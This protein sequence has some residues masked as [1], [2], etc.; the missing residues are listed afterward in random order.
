[1]NRMEEIFERFNLSQEELLLLGIGLLFLSLA[2]IFVL[3]L[4]ASRFVKSYFQRRERRLKDQYGKILNKIIIHETYSKPG[5]RVSSFDFRMA[6]LRLVMGHSNF[7]QQ[8]LIGHLLLMKKNLTGNAVGAILATYR[9][10]ELYKLSLRKLKSLQWQKK[11][12]GIR[13][14]AEMK[15]E[16]G[17]RVIMRFLNARN[18]TL[19]EEIFMALVRMEEDNPLFFLDQYNGTITH[20]MLINIHY[21]LSRLDVRKLPLFSRWFSHPDI[22]VVIFSVHMV[23]Q[24]RQSASIPGVVSLLATD[25]PRLLEIVI[26][27]L[28]EL[29]AYPYVEDVLRLTERVWSSEGLSRRLVRCVGSLG[30]PARHANDVVRFLEHSDYYVRFEAALALEKLEPEGPE[31]LERFN[32]ANGRCLE[33]IIRH[34]REPL[35]Q[36][37]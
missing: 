26:E 7:N 18:Q 15:H 5:Q 21:Y 34:I 11:A 35:L 30:E 36:R 20:W 16:E 10:L 23:R 31:A 32:H 3:I 37:A 25:H 28:G 22:S 2:F 13:E 1:M 8:V 27:T 6:E 19:R 14:L 4:F 29:E 12:L 33:G 24:F 17:T 9:E